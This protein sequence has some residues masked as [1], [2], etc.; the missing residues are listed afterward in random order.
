MPT[1]QRTRKS[2]TTE[3]YFTPLKLAANLVQLLDSKINLGR[4]FKLFIEPSAGRGAFV[5]ALKSVVRHPKVLAYDLKPRRRLIEQANFLKKKRLPQ[6]V[7]RSQVL[8]I[9]NPPFGHKGSIAAQFIKKCANISDHIAFILPISF[10]NPKRTWWIPPNYKLVWSK[11]LKGTRFVT[12]DPL[13]T[14]TLNVAF[15]YLKHMGLGRPAK[16]KPPAERPPNPHAKVL[17]APLL[18]ERSSAD[19]RVR[20]TGSTAGKSFLRGDA[21]F[22]TGKTR[23]DDWYIKITNP[24]VNLK[25][26][27]QGLNSHRWSFRNLVP[28]VKYLDRGQLTKVLDEL[29][30]KL[31]QS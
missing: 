12:D 13:E 9:G 7:D 19:I 15:V 24:K 21:D 3:S 27:C 26:L 14:K 5:D 28:N 20:G 22:G 16:L 8:C 4:H 31:P 23:S 17:V 2:V 18:K 10:L 1:H 11:S 25:S 6:T 29:T 30:M